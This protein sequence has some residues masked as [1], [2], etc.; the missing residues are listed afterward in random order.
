M[1]SPS[2]A[3]DWLSDQPDRFNLKGHAVTPRGVNFGIFGLA[4]SGAQRKCLEAVRCPAPETLSAKNGNAMHSL[5]IRI[6]V[7]P[8]SL[9]E[10]VRSRYRQ[11]LLYRRQVVV[12]VW[13]SRAL[14]V[15]EGIQIELSLQR[16]Q[17]VGHSWSRGQGCRTL[18]IQMNGVQLKFWV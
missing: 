4:D 11:A 10:A 7:R 8:T 14:Q 17:T 16:L 2:G 18:R 15:K 1:G 6:S 5:T 12:Q 13:W 3:S 9:W